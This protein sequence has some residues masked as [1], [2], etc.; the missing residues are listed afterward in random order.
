MAYLSAERGKNTPS[1]IVSRQRVESGE[2]R[3]EALEEKMKFA[4]DFGRRGEE[5]Q[6]QR[7]SKGTGKSPLTLCA[8]S[9]VMGGQDCYIIALLQSARRRRRIVVVTSTTKSTTKSS[10]GRGSGS[11]KPFFAS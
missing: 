5:E 8:F 11:G 2:L 6:R 4:E 1:S 3:V 10:T 9:P 7:T